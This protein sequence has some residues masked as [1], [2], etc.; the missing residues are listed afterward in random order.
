MSSGGKRLD[1][2]HN[3]KGGQSKAKVVRKEETEEG[4]ETKLRKQLRD[5][6]FNL[7][8]VRSESCLKTRPNDFPVFFF[9]QRQEL[10]RMARVVR[11]RDSGE[12]SCKTAIILSSTILENDCFKRLN[13]V[14][15]GSSS[16]LL[17]NKRAG[18][19]FSFSLLHPAPP[20]FHFLSRP[21]RS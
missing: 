17:L 1:I 3:R 15:E 8:V 16:K 12:K 19:R 9:F 6:W 18:Q 5:G 7:S 2:S 11:G 10:A 21:L 20:F 13:G 4:G 14:E